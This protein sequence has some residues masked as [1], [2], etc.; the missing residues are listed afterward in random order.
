MELKIAYLIYVGLGLLAFYFSQCF[1]IVKA[2]E[3]V[4]TLTFGKASEFLKPG[5]HLYLWLISELLRYET[6]QMSFQFDVPTA[7]TKSGRVESYQEDG[8]R[9]V[10]KAEVNISLTLTTYFSESRGQLLKTIERAPGH[11]AASLAPG[12]EP[13]VMDVVRGIFS[14][15]PWILS[16]QEQTK[17]RSYILS[18]I[19][20]SYQ[21][22]PLLGDGSKEKPYCF[23]KTMVRSDDQTA[24]NSYNPFVQF[25]LDTSRT[26]L[27]IEDINFSDKDL[28]KAMHEAE[29]ARL[30]I[31]AEDIRLDYSIRK[32]KGE[33]AAKAEA[34]RL[35]GFAAAEVKKKDGEANAANIKIEGAARANVIGLEGTAKAKA[36]AEMVAAIKDNVD[37]EVLRAL[38]EM[39]KGTSNTILY[40]IPNAFQDRISNILG[41]NK[42]S[43]LLDILKDKDVVEMIKK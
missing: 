6:T 22:Y 4:I 19:I 32:I 40:Q 42:P 12:I 16:Y 20:P 2:N 43:E 26:S 11:D 30:N 21:Y 18:R 37:L 1:F 27:S 3:R 33:G 25:G 8:G 24:M 17:V 28:A 7:I 14:E 39:A 10:E 9:P 15:M 36:R 41:N 13:Y 5:L 29:K 23:G 38:E 34:G 35:A 31:D